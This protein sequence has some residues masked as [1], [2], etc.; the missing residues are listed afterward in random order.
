MSRTLIIDSTF[1]PSIDL[2]PNMDLARSFRH[3]AHY[4]GPGG[5]SYSMILINDRRI[6]ADSHLTGHVARASNAGIPIFH[7]SFDLEGMLRHSIADEY[8]AGQFC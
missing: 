8:C 3:A 5:R 7:Y 2:G 4:L 1:D 6:P